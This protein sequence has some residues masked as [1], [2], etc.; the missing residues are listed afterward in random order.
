M[1]SVI[2]KVKYGQQDKL[3]D[4]VI[5]KTVIVLGI[6]TDMKFCLLLF[7]LWVGKSAKPKKPIWK[8]ANRTIICPNPNEQKWK[9]KT[10]APTMVKTQREKIAY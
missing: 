7:Q 5:N 3:K 9:M 1:K 10:P 8:V 2:K 6:Y 4:D